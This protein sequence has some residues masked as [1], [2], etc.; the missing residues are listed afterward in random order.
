M[1]GQDKAAVPAARL[2]SVVLRVMQF[3]TGLLNTEGFPAKSEYQGT[4]KRKRRLRRDC[5]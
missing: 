2:P 1:P 5:Q 4:D 3:W